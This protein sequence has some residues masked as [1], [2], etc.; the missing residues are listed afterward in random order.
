VRGSTLEGSLLGFLLPGNQ[1]PFV[2]ANKWTP[3]VSAQLKLNSCPQI[4]LPHWITA[5]NDQ[6]ITAHAYKTRA[7]NLST[8][9]FYEIQDIFWARDSVETGFVIRLIIR[10]DNESNCIVQTV[11]FSSIS[12]ASLLESWDFTCTK[13]LRNFFRGRRHA[14][15]L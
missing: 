7:K 8:V 3:Y 15:N 14:H 13:S 1:S 12:A 6:R 11:L 9:D 5:F 10:V 4:L 2:T